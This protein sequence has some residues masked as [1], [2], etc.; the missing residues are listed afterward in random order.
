MF[1]EGLKYAEMGLPIIP[2][3]SYNHE[4]IKP[5]SKHLKTCQCPGKVPLVAWTEHTKTERV[6]VVSWHNRFKTYNWGLAMGDK[7]LLIGIDIDGLEGEQI[8]QDLRGDGELPDTWQFTTGAG[9]R[10]LYRIPEGMKTKKSV[11]TGEGKHEECSILAEGQCTVIPPSIHH[12]GKRYEWVYGFSPED[13]DCADAPVWLLDLVRADKK[14]PEKRLEQKQ[15]E[16]EQQQAPESSLEDMF[17]AAASTFEDVGDS[18]P[19]AE[20]IKSDK[21]KSSKSKSKAK[22]EKPQVFMWQTLKGLD[23]TEG[24]RDVTMMQFIGSIMADAKMRSAGF[25]AIKATVMAYNATRMHPPLEEETIM[26]KLEKMWA[27]EETKTSQYTPASMEPPNAVNGSLYL[28]NYLTS[29]GISYVFDLANDKSYYHWESPDNTDTWILDSKDGKMYNHFVDL[30]CSPAFNLSDWVDPDKIKKIIRHHKMVKASR[31]AKDTDLFSDVTKNPLIRDYLPCRGKLVNWRTGEVIPWNPNF[32][33]T[34]NF[35]V[36]YDPDAKCPFWEQY[37][38]EW[39]P[40][41]EIRDMLQEFMGNGLLAQP[42][43]A[44]KF[45]I[46]YG[47]GRNGKSMFLETIQR[48]IGNQ[49]FGTAALQYLSTQFGATSI[50][51]KRFNICNELDAKYVKDTGT[52]KSMVTGEAFTMEF[53]GENSFAYQPICSFVFATN[54]L[55][56]VSDISDGWDR[57]RVVVPFEQKFEK[58]DAAYA[59][60]MKANLER[61][62]SGIF[63]WM[64]AG[65]RR[66]HDR[67][68]YLIP[69]EIQQANA[70][71]KKDQ[72]S[73][74]RF[75]DIFVVPSDEIRLKARYYKQKHGISANFLYNLYTSWLLE[76]SGE[77]AKPKGKKVFTEELERAGY[78][79]VAPKMHGLSGREC[80]CFIDCDFSFNE[81]MYTFLQDLKEALEGMGDDP[82]SQSILGA[83]V[84]FV[85]LLYR[86]CLDIRDNNGVIKEENVRFKK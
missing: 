39:V 55:P 60:Q 83:H 40:N 35:D 61:E 31:Q 45:L 57:R 26:I 1:Q 30:M 58:S 5:D 36:T 6:D 51:Q 47:S 59:A 67:G 11:N 27:E 19:E 42:D 29:L 44:G 75:L 28:D 63:N 78:K 85:K 41:P 8:L 17:F 33:T 70:A 49:T 34:D 9:R 80:A 73:V 10:L 77:N 2:F 22:G 53:K 86:Q 21:E 43:P 54:V 69:D 62:R 25:E 4:D 79:K 13:V 7:T 48:V 46:L 32:L 50:Y 14:E 81:S 56:K 38:T 72:D 84:E 20:E 82:L 52:L 23:V 65:L 64:L 18:I 68:N 37:L 74:L 3:C 76:E 12:T 16:I 24:G 71:A 66:F 15:I